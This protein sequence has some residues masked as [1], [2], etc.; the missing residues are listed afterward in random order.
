MPAWSD[1]DPLP[2]LEFLGDE[3]EDED[4][5]SVEA[6]LDRPDDIDDSEQ[7]KPEE[8]QSTEVEL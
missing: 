7:P 4:D 8:L 6:M 1:I 2:V 5:E 3:R